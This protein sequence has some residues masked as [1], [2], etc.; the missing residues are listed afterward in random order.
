MPRFNSD[1]RSH[2]DSRA[3]FPEWFKTRSKTWAG[4]HTN[5]TVLGNV[6]IRD[7]LNGHSNMQCIKA[8]INAVIINDE[9]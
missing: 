8:P 6:K 3:V 5:L 4:V 1:H 9:W 7:S 2:D